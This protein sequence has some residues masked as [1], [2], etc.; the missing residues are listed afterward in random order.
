MIGILLPNK[1]TLFL[2]ELIT[3]GYINHSEKV[4]SEL[5]SFFA[6][7]GHGL[8]VES[9]SGTRELNYLL[10]VSPFLFVTSLNVN[11]TNL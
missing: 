2:L 9:H 4:S 6:T 1:P 8:R 3:I 11:I 7:L 10:P 5:L